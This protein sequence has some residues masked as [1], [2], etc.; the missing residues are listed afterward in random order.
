MWSRNP[1]PLSIA[2][3][4]LL[5]THVVLVHASIARGIIDGRDEK[6]QPLSEANLV[7][8]TKDEL[9]NLLSSRPEGNR[10]VRGN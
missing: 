10:R 2:D 6:P 1:R 5:R 7:T 4:R 9:S 8:K 3:F